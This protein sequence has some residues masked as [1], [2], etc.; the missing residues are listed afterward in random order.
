MLMIGT[1]SRMCCY[2]DVLLTSVCFPF[3]AFFF[4][5]YTPFNRCHRLPLRHRY[6]LF[7][8]LAQQNALSYM[9]GTVSSIAGTTYEKR[10]VI[11]N[12][13]ENRK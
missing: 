10:I 2:L 4:L 12:L 9:N 8:S 5:L 7:F 3:T 6:R 11:R 13:L 1:H